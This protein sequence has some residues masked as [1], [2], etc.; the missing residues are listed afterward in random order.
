MKAG[1]WTITAD[2]MVSFADPARTVADGKVLMEYVKTPGQPPVTIMADSV[3][4]YSAGSLIDALGNVSIK[5]GASK[6]TA[7]EAKI[8][9]ADRT[10]TLK[11]SAVVM[12]GQALHFT[13]RLVEK[14]GENTFRLTDTLITACPTEGDKS[15]DW[16]IRCSEAN[17]TIDGMAYLKHSSLWAKKLPFLYTPFMVLPAKINRAS[18]FLFPELSHSSRSGTGLVTP[19]F[20]NLSPS[21]DIT[22]YPGYYS[23]RG[24]LTG[25]NVRHVFDFHS[26]LAIGGS[27]LNDKSE[28]LGPALGNEDYRKDGYLRTRKDRYWLRG[29]ADHSFSSHL[30]LKVDLDVVSDQDYLH[31][32]RESASGFDKS[33]REMRSLFKRSFQEASL[34]FRESIIHLSGRGEQTSG[35]IELR[36]TDDTLSDY[37]TVTPVHTLPRIV[38]SSRLPLPAMG[39]SFGLDSE[40]VNYYRKEGFGYH[41][42]DMAPR[43]I[44]SVPLGKHVEGTVSAG[45][46]ETLYQIETYGE[47]GSSSWT[48]SNSSNRNAWEISANAATVLVRN[49]K[50]DL[51]KLKELKH[52]FRPNLKYNYLYTGD[53]SKF[54]DLDSNDRLAPGNLLTWQLNNY[55]LISTIDDKDNNHSRNLGSVKLSQSF[56]LKESRRETTGTN[57]KRRPLS[58]LNLDIEAYPLAN[59]YLRYYTTL[60]VYGNGVTAYTLTSHFNNSRSDSFSIDYNYQ[61]GSARDLA[62][63][64][65][66]K[67]HHLLSARYST[68]RSF[69][70][71]HKTNE[72]IG[73][74]YTPD[75]WTLAIDASQDSEDKRVMLTLS[76]TGIGKAWQW[77]RDN[78]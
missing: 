62:T 59:L 27:Y 69:L 8:N 67:L 18:G 33:N 25:V 63:T 20:V 65:R 24:A 35:G 30:A 12:A 73:L 60:D 64:A 68:S 71:D 78:L 7:R 15:P 55:F 23:E 44:T 1:A 54:P 61:K 13:G 66:I 43:L 11:E 42:L 16:S 75:C 28:D 38:L 45:F 70:T 48:S 34:D 50:P 49:F 77:D 10:G 58:G 2:R 40:Y 3:T 26:L 19:Y 56:D 31:E 36:Y 57:D 39:V 53:Q 29:M 72:S 47:N 74:I 14:T 17:I 76:L 46:H 6:I 4:Y 51:A 5:D 37:T 22:L 9:L 41:R 32:F 21:S 52:T